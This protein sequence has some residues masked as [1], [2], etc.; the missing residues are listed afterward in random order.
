MTNTAMTHTRRRTLVA[1]CTLAVLIAAVPASTQTRRVDNGAVSMKA[2]AFYYET[3]LNPPT[4]PLADGSFFGTH[5]QTGPNQVHRMLLDR[6]KR[7]YFGYTVQIEPQAER[8]TFRLIFQPLTLTPS[9]R[10]R[11]GDDPSAWKAL[12][13]T[14]F[15]APQVIRS[16]EV[17]E[18]SLLSNSNWGQQLMEYVTVQEPP[19]QEGFRAF[20]QPTR[21]FSFAPGPPHD[22]AVSDIALHLEEPRMFI[23]G[24]FEESSGRTMGEETGGVVWIFVPKQG[25]FLLSVIPNPKQ[26]F[27]K[28]GEIRG[29]SLRFAVGGNTYS[30]TCGARIAPGTGAYN[31]YVLQQPDWRPSY[32]NANLD[33]ITIGAAERVEY[34]LAK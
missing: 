19:R 25:R 27:R 11:L 7:V 4:P 21:E 15:P 16:G 23:N 2:F 5:D 29:N 14:K 3:Q 30:V 24:Q 31:L 9:L 32:P 12:P 26:G 13:S 22:L 17:L 18:L 33:V 20:D 8:N 1:T 28:A 34:L 10:Q 6:T